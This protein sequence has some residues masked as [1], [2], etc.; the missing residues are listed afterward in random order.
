MSLSGI[1]LVLFLTFHMLMN[2]TL[3]FSSE[4]YDTICMLLGT[5]WY[6]I[7]GT[8]VLAF[9]FFVHI[10]YAT[11]LTL[12]NRKAR[13]GDAYASSNKTKTEWA[14]KNMFVLGLIIVGLLLLHLYHFWYKMQF[15]ELFHLE[16]AVSAGSGLVIGL[17]SQPI[18]TVIYLIWLFAIW[19]HLTH[20]IW[21]SFQ[22]I[23]LNN[24]T[25]FPRLKTISNIYAT[26][27]MIGFAVVPVYFTIHALFF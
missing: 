26:I 10:L 22:S 16:G 1:F 11:I 12:Q 9:G 19:F 13:G 2:I 17:F 4:V 24:K 27:L 15:S 18:Y 7:I 20:G 21:S 8:L 5:N 6:A 23:G 25:W 14:A 3:V